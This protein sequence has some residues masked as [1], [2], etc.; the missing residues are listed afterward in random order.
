[1]ALPPI[2]I[3][4]SQSPVADQML[5]SFMII[6]HSSPLPISILEAQAANTP[7]TSTSA[8]DKISWVCQKPNEISVSIRIKSETV[9]RSP[10]WRQ[11]SLPGYG[12][13]PPRQSIV[14]YS[15]TLQFGMIGSG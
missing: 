8:E 7:P 5:Q 14:K 9:S 13:L 15:S 10:S 11:I 4:R 2:G 12:Q 1:M 6:D 3:T